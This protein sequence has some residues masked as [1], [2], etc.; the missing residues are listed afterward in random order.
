MERRADECLQLIQAIIAGGAVI[1]A[2]LLPTDGLQRIQRVV[3][4]EH[5]HAINTQISIL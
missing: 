2:L 3:S 1:D 5:P 4:T